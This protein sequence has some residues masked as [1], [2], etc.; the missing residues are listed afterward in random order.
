[1][2]L[3]S[4]PHTTP[5]ER[6]LR[7]LSTE[8]SDIIAIV[9]YILMAGLLSLAVPLASQAL[10]NTIA[11][12]VFIQPLVVLTGLLLLGLL[13]AGFM[14]LMQFS[15]VELIQ[16]RI[17]ARVAT[18][19]ANHLP[20]ITHLSLGEHY[21]PELVNRFFD[22]VTIQKT[23]SKLLLN[24]PTALLQAILGL[25]LMGIYSPL[26][27]GFDIFVL[28]AVAFIIFVVGRNGL[29]NSL[30]ESKQKY[31]VAGWLEDIAR[32]Q[33]SL[34]I[35]GEPDFLL[36]KTDELVV[37]YI[38]DRRAHFKVLFRQA[39]GNY[40]FQAIASAG[41]LAIGGWL[42]INRQLTLGQLVASEIVVVSVL[43]A[44][45]KIILDLDEVY[46]LL[47][48]LDKVGHL[49]DMP[50]ESDSGSELQAQTVGLGLV[51]KDVTFGYSPSR[52]ILNGLNLTLQPGDKVS[53]VG[54]SGV[55]KSTLAAL[56]CGLL[57][58]QSG[59]IEMNGMDVRYLQLSSLRRSVALVGDSNDVFEGS[60]YDNVALGRSHVT[61][62]DIQWALEMTLMAEDVRRLPEGLETQLVSTGKNLSR[63]QIQRLMVARAI[64]DKPNL[65]ILDE[66]FTGLDENIKLGILD[67]MF[68]STMPWT[69]I[70][71]SHD[72]EVVV[73]A[74][75]IFVM[76]AG[77]IVQ[78]G[79]PKQLARQ[80]QNEFSRLFP[81]LCARIRAKA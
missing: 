18:R 39:I 46:D 21:A 13:M 31:K 74:D 29:K 71:I 16:Q 61:L 47:T 27:L 60:I 51:C 44:F 1:M 80:L 77:A 3:H 57:P 75:S 8:R 6:L 59:S 42:V 10:V 73:R 81:D 66:A 76:S 32:C 50:T 26:L 58:A 30:V 9:L 28:L 19:L 65:L 72:A 35:D 7:L 40:L 33:V 52:L 41:V 49:L 17:F 23:L 68:A 43:M 62:Q 53:L 20:R 25:L 63:G 79:S 55:G 5:F 69:I 37:G 36:K 48:A 78:E 4:P 45:Q 11:A 34:K 38:H 15:I 67:N 54:A 70:D 14:K 2:T 64:V 12:G 22:V 56:L 24:F